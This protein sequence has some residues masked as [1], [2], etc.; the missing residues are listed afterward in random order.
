MSHGIFNMYV[1]PLNMGFD[2]KVVPSFMYPF[3]FWA[4]IHKYANLINGWMFALSAMS[5]NRGLSRP[6]VLL[7]PI[8]HAR[9]LQSR[10]TYIV[11]YMESP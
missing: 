10:C 1:G 5:L 6:H 7:L 8:F 4:L 11:G 2:H 3:L 9:F